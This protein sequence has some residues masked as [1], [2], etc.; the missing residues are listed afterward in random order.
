VVSVV[1][2]PIS[3]GLVMVTVTAGRTA[4]VASVTTPVITPVTVLTVC[5]ATGEGQR[6]TQ[7]TGIHASQP[8]R[9]DHGLSRVEDSS[10]RE[11]MN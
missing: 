3:A 8:E 9:M 1:R 7:A 6:R 2:A 10:I 5:P 11:H 4:P